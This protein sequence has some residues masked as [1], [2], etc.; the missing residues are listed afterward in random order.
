MEKY[1]NIKKT[2]ISKINNFV[3][4]FQVLEHIQEFVIS[5]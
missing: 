5:N 3:I 1:I 2:F 4:N